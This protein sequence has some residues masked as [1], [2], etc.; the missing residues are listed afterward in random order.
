[1]KNDSCLDPVSISFNAET[2]EENALEF[3]V[4]FSA[5]M[6]AILRGM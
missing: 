5:A 2:M 3:K 4:T 1:V 6:P